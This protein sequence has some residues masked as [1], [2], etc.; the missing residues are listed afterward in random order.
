MWIRG[1]AIEP[2][3]FEYNEFE[4]GRVLRALRQQRRPN[5]ASTASIERSLEEV[6]I[7]FKPSGCG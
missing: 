4:A 2:Q 1:L 7:N 5:P 6:L 3:E